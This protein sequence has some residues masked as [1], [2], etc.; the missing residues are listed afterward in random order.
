MGSG[1]FA[2]APRFR[3]RFGVNFFIPVLDD[4]GGL[5]LSTVAE[6]IVKQGYGIQNKHDCVNKVESHLT[7]SEEGLMLEGLPEEGSSL[8]TIVVR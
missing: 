8:M 5:L 3:K 6:I 2:I 7:A 1:A 4:S